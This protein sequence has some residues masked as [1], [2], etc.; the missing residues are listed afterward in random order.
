MISFGIDTDTVT[1]PDLLGLADLHIRMLVHESQF[2][3]DSL[4]GRHRSSESRKAIYR[5][6]DPST[7]TFLAADTP[8]LA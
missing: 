8:F 3:A 6:A 7:P 2:G 4:P 1:D 5:P